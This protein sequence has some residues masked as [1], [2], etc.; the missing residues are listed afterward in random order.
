MESPEN[1]TSNTRAAENVPSYCGMMLRYWTTDEGLEPGTKNEVA[2][3][4]F[5]VDPGRRM[6]AQLLPPSDLDIYPGAAQPRCQLGTHSRW[7]IRRPELLS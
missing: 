7:S 2:F 5:Q 1:A 6:I 4:L 3:R